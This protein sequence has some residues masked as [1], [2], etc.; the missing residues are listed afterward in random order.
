M[1]CA[2]HTAAGSGASGLAHAAC[3]TR[4]S[5]HA[6]LRT[7]L[8]GG[9]LGGGLGGGDGGRGGGG[10]GLGGGLGGGLGKG[11][12][13]GGGSATIVTVTLSMKAVMSKDDTLANETVELVV[14]KGC[15]HADDVAR[16]NVH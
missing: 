9:G 12:G 3:R 13:L 8:G 7:H 16:A 4:P 11:G 5:P 15:I 6:P 14:P 1:G 10:L 2:A